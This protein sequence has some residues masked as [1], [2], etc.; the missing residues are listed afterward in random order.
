MSSWGALLLEAIEPGT[1]LV[2]SSAYPDL[3]RVGELLGSLHASGVPDPSYPTVAQRVA[4]L[5]DASTK[6][7]ER[8]PELTALV[9]P[10]LYERGRRLATRLAQGASPLVLLHGDLTPSNLLDGGAERGLVAIDP[11]PCLGDGAFDAVDLLCWQADDVETIQARAERLAAATAIHAERLLGWCIAFAGMIALE[12]ASQGNGA[13]P[14]TAA[15][16]GLA[17]QAPTG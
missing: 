10:E 4:Y 8:H 12:L 3:E 17:A 14:A 6:L 11:A 1:P 7:Y 5:F 13:R 2:V 15:L 16:L 9:R